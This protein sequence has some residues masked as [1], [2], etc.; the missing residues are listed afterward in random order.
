MIRISF[1]L[2]QESGHVEA[3]N[4]GISL[5]TSKYGKIAGLKATNEKIFYSMNPVTN[6]KIKAN[7]MPLF[8]ISNAF[9][10][11]AEFYPYILGD[12]TSDPRGKTLTQLK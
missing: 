6:P 10:I 4:S 7:D 2:L 1:M 3:R 11:D 12:I 8:S 9:A 5:A